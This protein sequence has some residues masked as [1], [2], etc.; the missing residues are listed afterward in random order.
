LAASLNSRF[1]ENAKI[2]AG[3]SGQFDV[4]VDGKLIFSKSQSGRFPVD[5]EVEEIF[6]ALKK[7]K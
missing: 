6:E 3:K 4:L 1:G 7:P 5:D 2:T